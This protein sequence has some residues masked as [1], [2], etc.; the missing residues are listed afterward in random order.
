MFITMLEEGYQTKILQYSLDLFSG[1]HFS[2]DHLQYQNS[3]E[4]NFGEKS[5]VYNIC[6]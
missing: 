2:S 6:V 3:I 5:C 4:D 1:D